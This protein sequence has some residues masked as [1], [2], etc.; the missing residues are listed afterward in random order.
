MQNLTSALVEHIRLKVDIA[1]H[2]HMSESFSL[3]PLTSNLVSVIVGGYDDL[4]DI[5]NVTTTIEIA[6]HAGETIRI[7]R[8]SQIEVGDGMLVLQILNE[9]FTRGATGSVR[10]TLENSGEADIEIT[11]A[12]NSGN[13]DSNEIIWYLLDQDENVIATKAFRQSTGAQ[14]VTLANGNSV[15]RVAAGATFTSEA[16]TIEVPASAPDNVI[17]RNGGRATGTC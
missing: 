6:P 11:C 10:F 4:A 2:A 7:V 8:T 3:Q 14:V 15:A 13:A 17:A 16:T 1:G 5:E 12:Q 9:E